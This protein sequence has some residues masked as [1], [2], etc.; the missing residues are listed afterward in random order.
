MC[1]AANAQLCDQINDAAINRKHQ[2]QPKVEDR[3]DRGRGGRL[4][5]L[6]VLLAGVEQPT[7][8]NPRARNATA[9]V[10]MLPWLLILRASAVTASMSCTLMTT[11]DEWSCGL[12]VDDVASGI[13]LLLLWCRRLKA[14]WSCITM[15]RLLFAADVVMTLLVS[16]CRGD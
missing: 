6:T 8:S 7:L 5:T 10:Y 9:L 16:F 2:Q 14:S 1:S 4:T 12:D 15:H 11:M 3:A 13:F